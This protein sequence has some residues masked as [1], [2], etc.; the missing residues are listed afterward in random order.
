MVITSDKGLCGAFNTNILKAA[1]KY[2]NGL[3]Q[4]GIEVSLSVVGRKARDFFNRRNIPMRN[5]WIGLS[6]KISYANAQEIAE[7]L[8]ENYTNETFDEVVD[9]LQ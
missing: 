1:Y 4:E 9:Y 7:N 8:M 6:G 3:K 5:A 2:I